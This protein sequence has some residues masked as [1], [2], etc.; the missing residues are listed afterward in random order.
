MTTD[1][2]MDFL[3][4]RQELLF[5]N[6]DYSRLLFEHKVTQEQSRAISDVFNE[7]RLK[8]D[9]GE[10]VHSGIFEQQIYE[11]VPQHDGN[12]HFVEFLAQTTHEDGRW[13]EVFETLYGDEMKF[14][15]YMKKHRE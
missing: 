6:S 9:S 8:I 10:S 11:V 5:E 13:T 15:A 2:R 7:Y 3:E 14:K 12:Y 1:E 4:Y